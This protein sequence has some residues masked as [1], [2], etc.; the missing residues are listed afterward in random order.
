MS[1]RKITRSIV[2]FEVIY[3]HLRSEPKNEPR[4][5]GVKKRKF[6]IEREMQ[7]QTA[8]FGDDLPVE[9]EEAQLIRVRSTFPILDVNRDKM[10]DANDLRIVLTKIRAPKSYINEAED[11]IWEVN[12]NN[13][14]N[15]LEK[16]DVE[17]IVKRV[18]DDQKTTMREPSRLINIIDF[19]SQD[20]S[21]EG[22]ISA[23]QCILLLHNRFGGSV[24]SVQLRTLFI[25]NHSAG[26][27]RISFK[28]YLSQVNIRQ[29]VMS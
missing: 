21:L 19:V 9:N 22:Y 7:S 3:D 14:K 26:S 5:T 11:I 29:A 20:L 6:T 8:N 12:D 27:S 1:L 24:K 17:R 13:T 10:I 23:R 18:M 15:Y 4:I 16:K 25:N 28:D 2:D